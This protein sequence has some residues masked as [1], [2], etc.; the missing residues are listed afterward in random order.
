MLHGIDFMGHW[1]SSSAVNIVT[2][3]VFVYSCV[4]KVKV[5]PQTISALWLL[6]LICCG[7]GTTKCQNHFWWQEELQ[8]HNRL[9]DLRSFLL[10]RSCETGRS[11]KPYTFLMETYVFWNPSLFCS[12]LWW[13]WTYSTE[14]FGLTEAANVDKL[15]HLSDQQKIYLK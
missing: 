9:V 12:K 7:M 10:P 6:V 11:R 1:N 3:I 15:W 5:I 4:E 14:H 8:S 13:N 2:H